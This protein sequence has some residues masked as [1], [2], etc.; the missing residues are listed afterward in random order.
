VAQQTPKRDLKEACLIEAYKIIK[1]QGLAA[2]SLRDVARRLGVSHQAPYRH[3][4]S[5]DHVLAEIIA[6]TFEEFAVELEKA[7]VKSD[8]IEALRQ[9]GERYL[10]YAAANPLKYQLMFSTPMPD[11]DV[12]PNMMAKAKTA[13]EILQSAL[14]RHPRKL[15]GRLVMQPRDDA[16]FVWSALHGLASILQSDALKTL[17]MSQ[18]EKHATVTRTFERIGLAL[19]EVEP[20]GC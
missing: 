7:P 18:A 9:M 10:H 15:A 20:G 1:E 11:S 12:H 3:F 13:F 14:A 19:G 4:A 2:L 17:G 5:R 16:M 8:P 6:R